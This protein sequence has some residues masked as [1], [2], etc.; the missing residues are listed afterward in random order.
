[1][2]SVTPSQI[3]PILL[4]LWILSSKILRVSLTHP[5]WEFGLFCICTA[6]WFGGLCRYL[7]SQ[8]FVSVFPVMAASRAASFQPLNSRRGQVHNA[9]VNSVAVRIEASFVSEL[10]R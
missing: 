10:L 8:H 5:L 3:L 4:R 1:M 9:V 7:Q 6:Q 2:G